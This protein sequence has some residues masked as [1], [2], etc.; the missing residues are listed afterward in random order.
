[1]HAN[2]SNWRNVGQEQQQLVRPSVRL[3]QY[4]TK[5]KKKKKERIV[6]AGLSPTRE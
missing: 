3:Q 5:K 6:L 4:F 1:L 2:A